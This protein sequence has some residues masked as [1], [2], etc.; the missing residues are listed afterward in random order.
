MSTTMREVAPAVADPAIGEQDL[1]LFHEGTHLRAYRKLGA[2][3]GTVDGAPGATFAVWAP[4]AASV[5]VIGDWNGW[6]KGRDELHP[7]GQG[8]LWQGF[9]AGVRSGSR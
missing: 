9:V 7:V 4:N 1:H 5:S 2:H 6:Q 8:G 3:L